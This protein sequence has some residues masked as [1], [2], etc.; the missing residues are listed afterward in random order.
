MGK[1]LAYSRP[2]L[3]T[4]SQSVRGGCL[5]GSGAT[6][7]TRVPSW[8]CSTGTD[9]NYYSAGC[10]P[11]AGD[12]DASYWRNCLDGTGVSGGACGAGN[13]FYIVADPGCGAGSDKSP[14]LCSV[15]AVL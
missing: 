3:R 11:G 4:M 14:S 8:N 12:T 13:S 1:K 6:D 7:S 10:I 2:K 9:A 5:S 15:G